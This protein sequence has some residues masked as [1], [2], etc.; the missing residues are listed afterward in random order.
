[1]DKR[2]PKKIIDC[3]LEVCLNKNIQEAADHS[4]IYLEEKIRLL[5][6]KLIKPGII[7]P[8]LLNV[9]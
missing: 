2:I 3:F 9:F 1:M 8:S 6:N 7:L 4:I 5:S